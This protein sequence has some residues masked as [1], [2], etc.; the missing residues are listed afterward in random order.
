MGPKRWLRGLVAGAV[1][2][3]LWGCGGGG[4]DDGS[5]ATLIAETAKAFWNDE[6]AGR[7]AF[8]Q[9]DRRP[10]G[11]NGRINLVTVGGTQTIGQVTATRFVHSSSLL[12][13]ESVDELRYFD[14]QAI[15]AVGEIDIGTGPIPGGYAELPAPMLDGVPT[16]VLD[17]SA[18]VGDLDFD[19]VADTGRLLIVTTLGT[20]PSRTV[21]AGAFSNVVRA[22]TDITVSI[23]LSQVKQT[24]TVSST[25][26]TWYAPGVGPIRREF[27]DPDPD[28]V[29]PNNVVYE[30]LSGVSIA[31]VKAG[32]VP[33]YVA[34][35]GIGAGSDSNQAG[36]PSIASGGERILIASRGLDAVGAAGLYGAILGTDGAEIARRTLVQP[37]SGSYLQMQSAAVFDGQNFQAFWVRPDGVLVGQRV[38]VDGTVL[39]APGGTPVGVGGEGSIKRI[40]AA[41]DANAV[42]LVWERQPVGGTSVL[43]GAIVDRNGST[44]V[45]VALGSGQDDELAAAWSSGT[46]LV[47]RQSAPGSDAIRFARVGPTGAVTSPAGSPPDP[48]WSAI[49]IESTHRTGVRVVGH[50]DGFFVGWANWEAPPMIGVSSTLRGRR[51]GSDGSLPDA[52][53]VPIDPVPVAGREQGVAL[54]SGGA[55][56]LAGSVSEWT[57]DRLLTA[58]RARAVRAPASGGV[59]SFGVAAPY[60]YTGSGT[61][62]PDLWP[63]AVGAGNSFVIAWLENRQGS[64]A[65]SDRVLAT[66]VHPPASR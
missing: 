6:T 35:D 45:P 39:G 63:V 12:D 3:L 44:T 65:T 60:W 31:A 5:S 34:L 37:S 18:S 14:G 19:G 48:I 10:G 41:S 55:G 64:V 28:L 62:A 40:A 8:V 29:A 33:G 15:R 1:A 56:L 42:L 27:V 61:D 49:P 25:L 22:R 32:V 66:F 13:G 2:T 58:D 59:P 38:S 43:E 23:T 36:M 51:I 52:G 53:S 54:A 4:G 46:Y 47:T 26:T 24:V 21:P 50:P 9:T 57:L 30:E 20:E 16:T 11:A 17:Q 7:W